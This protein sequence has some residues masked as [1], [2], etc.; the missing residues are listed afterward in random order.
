MQIVTTIPVNP[1]DEMYVCVWM[2]RPRELPDL[3]GNAIFLIGNKTIKTEITITTPRMWFDA[4]GN[5][6]LTVVNGLEADWV[7]EAPTYYGGL[8]SDLSNYTEAIMMNA[9]VNP[10]DSTDA[11][12]ITYQSGASLQ[13]TMINGTNKI[14]TVE[15]IDDRSMR[16]KWHGFH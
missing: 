10:T 3:S 2:G 6:I 14:S 7:I 12:W 1:G 8:Q 16:F 4:A 5:P 15:A 13:V 9:Y 11:K